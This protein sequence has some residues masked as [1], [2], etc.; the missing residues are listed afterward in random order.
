MKRSLRLNRFTLRSLAAITLSAVGMSASALLILPTYNVNVNATA[1]AAFQTAINYFQAQFTDNVTVRISVLFG[2]T[3]LGASNT[4]L[5]FVVP[6]TYAQVR[7]DLIADQLAH[8]SADGATSIGAGGS[9]NQAADPFAN[10]Q[11]LYTFAQAKALGARP[12]NDAA[13]DGTITFSN[14]Q[15]FDFTNT[16]AAGFDFIGVAEHE[17]SEVMGRIQ[18][19]GNCCGVAGAVDPYDLFNFSGAN[20]HTTGKGAGRYFSINNGVTDLVDFNSFTANGG[21][22]GDFLGLVANDP[23]NA[24]TGQNQAHTLNAVDFTN[25]DVIGWDR[26]QGAQV[27]EPGTLALFGIALS[28]LAWRRRKQ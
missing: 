2:N 16:G 10:T 19:N 17:I 24:F 5:Q 3:G 6:A 8:P 25:L 20:A 1:Q 12:A 22:S 28:G 9:I 13:T 7:A 26:V 15:P 23:F 27:P 14:A 4:S 21:D 11:Y 18:L